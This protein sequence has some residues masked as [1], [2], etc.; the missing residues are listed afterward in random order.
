MH[1]PACTGTPSLLGALGS[2]H[3][4]R[5]IHCGWQWAVRRRTRRKAS[6]QPTTFPRKGGGTYRAINPA[7]HA[8]ECAI[9][10]A[11]ARDGSN[12]S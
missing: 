9:R 10:E 5:C 4:Y 2:L 12:K 7:I 8:Q 3:H 1:C 11:I 6:P